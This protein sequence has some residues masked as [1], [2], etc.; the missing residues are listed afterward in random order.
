MMCKLFRKLFKTEG[1]RFP[2]Y[3]EPWRETILKNHIPL[4]SISVQDNGI[5]IPEFGLELKSKAAISII[6]EG[7]NWI[8]QLVLNGVKIQLSANDEFIATVNACRFNV[9]TS[10]EFYVL[11]EVFMT[12]D[13]DLDLAGPALILDVGANVGYSS[14]YLANKLDDVIIHGFEP[15]PETYKRAQCNLALNQHVEA[16]IHLHNFG[17]YHEDGKHT[18]L[19]NH[20]RRG[21]SSM[22]LTERDHADDC[23]EITIEV[24]QASTAIQEVI[25]AHPERTVIMKLDTEGSE[26]AILEELSNS[27]TWDRIACIMMEWHVVDKDQHPKQIAQTLLD[28]GF[29]LLKSEWTD[30]QTS[31]MI[32]GIKPNKNAR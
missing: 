24:R 26:Y 19:L 8:H 32:Y 13:Y 4:G 10:E 22:V 9:G 21:R 3:L 17:L 1:N 18:F 12:K 15:A 14:I 30:D 25:S 29:I 2:A 11:Y 20:S 6:L 7:Y 27:A 31:G 23:E 16:K 5:S 28:S